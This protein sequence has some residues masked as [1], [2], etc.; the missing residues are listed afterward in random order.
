MLLLSLLEVLDKVPGP[1]LLWVLGI[2]LGAAGYLLG[3][4]R[5]WLG[6]IPIT[7]LLLLALLLWTTTGDPGIEAALRAEA[8]N[9]TL[10]TYLPLVLGILASVVGIARGRRG[11]PRAA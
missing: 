9:Y 1:L 8:P 4:R 11:G 2:I 6:M 10:I 3:R 7:L 5:A